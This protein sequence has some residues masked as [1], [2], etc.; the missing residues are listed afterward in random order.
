[1]QHIMNY[2]FRDMGIM[3]GRSIRYFFLQKDAAITLISLLCWQVL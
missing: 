1:M 3:L 2:L